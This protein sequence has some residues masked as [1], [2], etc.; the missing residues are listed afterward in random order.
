MVHVYIKFQ[1]S[2]KQEGEVMVFQ[3]KCRNDFSYK[4]NYH[5][6]CWNVLLQL[7]TVI[8]WIYVK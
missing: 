8:Y 2:M 6:K 3:S 7:S 4:Q 5:L 1:I